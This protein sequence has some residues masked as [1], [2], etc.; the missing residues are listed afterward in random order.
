ML[1]G[2]THVPFVEIGRVRVRMRIDMFAALIL[3]GSLICG[4]GSGGTANTGS[5]GATPPSTPQNAAAPTI[6]NAYAQNGAVVVTLADL[7]T[8]AKIYY[9]LDG[10]TPSTTSQ[11]YQAPFLVSSNLIVNAIAV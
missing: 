1:S 3:V 9:T 10:S 11:Q 2:N 6:T 8:G 7:T 4:C 5:G